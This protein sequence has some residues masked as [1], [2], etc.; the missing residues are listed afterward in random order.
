MKQRDRGR[1]KEEEEKEG[2]RFGGRAGKAAAGLTAAALAAYGVYLLGTSRTRRKPVTELPYALNLRLDYVPWDD[3]LHYAYYSRRGRGRPIVFLHSIN[4]VASA[5]EMRPLV[6][7][8]QRETERPLYALEW[9]GFGHSDRPDLDYTPQLLEDQLEH[10]LHEVVK[11]PGGADVIAFSLGAT[12][13]AEVARRRPDLV[14]SL[15]ALEPVG[16]GEEP[17][18]IGRVWAGLLFTLPGVQRAFYDRLTTPEALYRFARDKLFTPEF[19][20]PEE[21]VEY[22]AETARVDGASRPL[23]D[24]LGGRLFPEYARESFRRLRQPLLVIYGTVEDR[25]QES[26]TALPELE[27]RPQVEVVPLPTGALPHWERPG[28]VFERIREFF[29]RVEAGATVSPA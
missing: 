3:E 4:A 6:Q 22:G 13:A 14:R 9:L 25:R 27:G 12:Y 5:H 10:W 16:L 2:G 29:D 19:G 8:F 11:A 23:D 18:E 26:F 15:V 7:R 24:F 1:G 21:Y 28:D 20:V 17:T